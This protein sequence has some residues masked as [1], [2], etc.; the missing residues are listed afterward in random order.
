MGDNRVNIIGLVIGTRGTG[1]TTYLKGDE[2]LKIEGI[3]D[4]YIDRD[5]K[6]KILIVDLFDNPI[7]K[8]IPQI[9]TEKLARW[10]SG[11]YRIYSQNFLSLT[12]IINTHCYNTIIIFEDATKYVGSKLDD[13]LKQLLLDSKQKNNDI[14]FA[15]HYMQAAAPDLV[16]IAD[17]VVLFKT[18][19]TFTNTI[20]NKYPHPDIER[21][22]KEVG[23]HKDFHYHK[24]VNLI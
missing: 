21:A 4:I 10:K 8:N 19:E 24:S 5:P 23:A 1:K 2:K 16:R 17:Y 12:A 18:N 15:F 11:I 13:N 7:W 14:F 22:F 6:Q 3:I 9:T 20:R